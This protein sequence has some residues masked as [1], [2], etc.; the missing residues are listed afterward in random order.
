M[1]PAELEVW[2]HRLAQIAEEMGEALRRTGFSPNIKERR[3]YS[4]ALFDSQ[5]RL[6]A[7]AAHIPVHL[8][9][10][11]L[12]VRALLE[13]V[14]L[15]DGET[16]IANDP[17]AGGTHLPDVTMVR[18]V[19]ASGQLLGYVACR[20]HHADI[21]GKT[22]GSMPVG[23]RGLGDR[24]P[25][26]V[27]PPPAVGDKYAEFVVPPQHV[28]TSSVTIDDEG[29][30]IE[31]QKIVGD[32]I[33]RLAARCRS[34]RE[35]RGDF[36]AQEAALE[37]G[38][39]RFIE[40]AEKYGIEE[41]R[42]NSAELLAYSARLMRRALASIPD[43]LYAFADSLDDDGAGSGEVS[44]RVL[45]E[46]ASEEVTVDFSD[47]DGEV[48]GSLNAVHAVTRAAVLYAFHLLLDEEA[49]TNDGLYDPITVITRPGSILDARP[50]RAVGA[51]NVETSQRVVDVVLGA[52]A[53]ALPERIPS[54]SAGTM[55]NLLIGNENFAYYETIAGGAGA[56][57]AADGAHAIQTHMTN[58]RNTPVELLE[59]LLPLRVVSY[60][61]RR[62]SGGGGTHRGGDG[63]V[64]TF[65]FLTD[66]TV[67]LI[68]E[69][70][71]RAPH[72]LAGGGPGQT[73]EDRVDR[74]IE[75]VRLP[76]KI[77]F[78]ARRG[79][80]LTI[81]TPG[82]GGYGDPVKKQFWANLLSGRAPSI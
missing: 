1:N 55:N 30:R 67:T 16:G 64:R 56:G 26:A 78:E 38:R 19:I 2:N 11:S 43:G 7:Q 40:L 8:G 52:L 12:A 82:G 13:R 62:G 31:P 69:R 80:R 54:A 14:V 21:G 10:T 45:V 42:A 73:G 71:R 28:A 33:D 59:E 15:T 50:P 65:E 72:G 34:P 27:S 57:P 53:A 32:L 47:S 49:P 37:V 23:Q 70:R 24:L 48:R 75:S 25:Q 22:P 9:S 18:P 35:R 46:K 5:M 76:G 58:T 17:Y 61:L 3:D 79:D 66:A 63:V 68:G 29:L 81:A 39:R 41:L 51:G 74:G 4:C 20:A 36:A 77:T 60:A 44:I 6:L